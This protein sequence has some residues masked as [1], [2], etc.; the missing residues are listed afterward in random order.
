MKCNDNVNSCTWV[1][2]VSTLEEHV[3]TCE[4]TLLP[5]PKECK[6]DSDKVKQLMRKDLNDHLQTDCPY[7]DCTCKDCGKEGTHKSMLNHDTECE[8]KEISCPEDGCSETITREDIP[9]HVTTDCPY[10][11]ISCK[12]AR[13]G[14]E[15]E[16]K[17]KDMAAHEQDDTVHLHMAL[18]TINSL[19]D[20]CKYEKQ[21]KFKLTGFQKKKKDNQ[22]VQSPS[23]YT[24]PNG[25]HMAIIV[26]ANGDG[27]EKGTNVTVSARFLKGKYDAQLKWPF[28]G[29][30][31][32]TL[33]NQ[34]EDKN[35]YQETLEV[36]ARDN[37]K[38]GEHL[39]GVPLTP[40][41]ELSSRRKNTQ[42]LKDDTL[43]FRMSVEP[44]NHKPWL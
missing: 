10:A 25:Y 8:K 35:H 29:E 38:V 27:P 3:A 16:L 12:Y 9:L 42:Y 22:C 37:A 41:S 43:Y 21:I 6:D 39:C 31:T 28:V 34:L 15:M 26:H 11:V 5:C 32:F 44:A 2:T 1:G 33:L 40:H 24:S 36:T 13:I 17:R 30:I 14:C 20:D 23:Y 18:D 19:R 7:R 4:F